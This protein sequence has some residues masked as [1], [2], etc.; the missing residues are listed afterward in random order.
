MSYSV[1]GDIPAEFHLTADS[2]L[3]LFILFNHVLLLYK[4]LPG[5]FLSI[6]MAVFSVSFK[7]SPYFAHPF[8]AK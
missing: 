5:T 2:L 6:I 4:S 8:S 1:S 7:S 3:I